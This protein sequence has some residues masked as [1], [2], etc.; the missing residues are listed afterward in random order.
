METIVLKY[1]P[2]PV[3]P[4]WYTARG[5]VPSSWD[6]ISADQFIAL[7]ELQKQIITEKQ[8]FC[9]F[10]GIP[11]RVITRVPEYFLWNIARQF[12][13]VKEIKPHNTFFIPEIVQGDFSLKSPLPV[14]RKM[15]FGQFIFADTRYIHW[16]TGN[17]ATD[18][19]K[20]VGSL[21]LPDGIEFTD[22][23][24][25]ATLQV[26]KKIPPAVKEA[27]ALNWHMVHEWLCEV[28]PL[29]FIK[30]AA[31]A[32]DKKQPKPASNRWIKIFEQIVGD[33]IINQDRYAA[34]PVHNVFR[35]MTAHI[36]RGYRSKPSPV[37]PKKPK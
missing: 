13:W 37:N 34:L 6:E 26:I 30:P 21:Y 17:D 35:F 36:R 9:R 14:L 20:F 31:G 3:V 10:T 28:Y 18:L 8:F 32:E 24:V 23:V 11:M 5:E 33:D 15:T 16:S 12:D 7:V 29:I 4:L 22:D 2:V 1:R 19:D 25:S 27:V